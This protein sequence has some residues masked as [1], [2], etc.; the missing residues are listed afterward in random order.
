MLGEWGEW[1]CLKTKPGCQQVP[2]PTRAA[3]APPAC[4]PRASGRDCHSLSPPSPPP[5][6]RAGEL[7]GEGASSQRLFISRDGQPCRKPRAE[8]QGQLE[9][10]QEACS[11]NGPPGGGGAQ[12]KLRR[13]EWAGDRVG[14]SFRKEAECL[15]HGGWAVSS[16]ARR[17][18]K[19]NK[20][21]F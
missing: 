21:K 6:S 10:R 5:P 17:N 9:R 1:G 3:E 20:E 18:Q 12:W 16:R 14:P 13:R 4:D 11:Q 19:Q 15:P 2:G 7:G 8:E